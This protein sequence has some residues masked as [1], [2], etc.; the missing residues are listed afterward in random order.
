MGIPQAV[1]LLIWV[2]VFIMYLW[3]NGEPKPEDVY[4][5][6]DAIISFFILTLP[7]YFGGFFNG[8]K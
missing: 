7:L 3:K 1:Y 6:R 4:D 8:C 2:A 5:L